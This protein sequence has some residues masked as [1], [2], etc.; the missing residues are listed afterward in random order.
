MKSSH[1]SSRGF[2]LIELLVVISIIGLLSSFILAALNQA[3]ARGVDASIITQRH[4]IEIAMENYYNDNGGYPNPSPGSVGTY[5]IGGTTCLL[6]GT[7][8]STELALADSGRTLAQTN[9]PL[10]AAAA[11]SFPAISSPIIYDTGGNANRGFIYVSCGSD[12]DICS[13][14]TPAYLISA[15]NA[16][17]IVEEQA[18]IWETQNWSSSDYGG[19]G[20]SGDY[21]GDPGTYTY[22]VDNLSSGDYV[23]VLGNGYGGEGYYCR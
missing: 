7:E 10:A 16:G 22:S 6:A 2:T 9:S 14:G 23:C 11:F 1:S 5:C 8:I 19:G 21:Y 15:T 4:Q 20:S 13:G 3:R 12:S 18:G 17:G